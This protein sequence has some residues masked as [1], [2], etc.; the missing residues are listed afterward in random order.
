MPSQEA[1]NSIATRIGH[2]FNHDHYY[3]HRPLPELH[4]AYPVRVA[5]RVVFY[6]RLH[7]SPWCRWCLSPKRGWR[8]TMPL[9]LL[10]CLGSARC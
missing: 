6:R 10:I 1:A 5:I 9:R 4:T 2:V 8:L 3:D 7:H